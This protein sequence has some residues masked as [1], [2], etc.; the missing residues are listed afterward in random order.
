MPV[1]CNFCGTYPTERDPRWCK[2]VQESW[3]CSWNQGPGNYRLTI[4]DLRAL[5]EAM[6]KSAEFQCDIEE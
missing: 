2:S 1:P 4:A 5:D 6:R 3:R